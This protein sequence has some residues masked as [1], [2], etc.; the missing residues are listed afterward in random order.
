MTMWSVPE[1]AERPNS[2]HRLSGRTVT[3]SAPSSP[4]CIS[5][6][7]RLNEGGRTPRYWDASTHPSTPPLRAAP[8]SGG[9]TSRSDGCNSA[10]AGEALDFRPASRG[11][12]PGRALSGLRV[13]L[14]ERFGTLEAA[15]DRMDFHADGHISCLEFQEVINGQEHYCSLQEAMKLFCML[16]RGT[17]GWLTRD[18]FIERLNAA[19]CSGFPGCGEPLCVGVDFDCQDSG[20]SWHSGTSSG[21]W[22]R[23]SLAAIP[24]I[25]AC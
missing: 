11:V 12:S 17:N 25:N 13:F 22:Q 15:L 7:A 14:V 20:A 21:S 9:H 19:N 6:R 4:A 10:R 3:S 1:V 2:P 16:A 24:A 18:A 8:R 23:S 5:S